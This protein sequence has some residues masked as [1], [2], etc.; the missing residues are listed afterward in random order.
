[1]IELKSIQEILGTSFLI[2][3]YQRGYRWTRRQVRDLL[4]DIDE[5][6]HKDESN[7]IYCIQPLVVH[8]HLDVTIDSIRAAQSIQEVKD[9]LQGTWDVVDGQQRLTTV[10]ILLQYLCNVLGWN[11]SLYQLQYETR[12][13]HNIDS[14]TFLNHITEEGTRKTAC[15][16]IDYY[17]FS[18]AYQEIEKWFSMSCEKKEK[19][20]RTKFLTTLLSQVKFIWYEIEEDTPEEVFT[21]LNIG[22]ISLTNSELIKALLLNRSNFSFKEID[23]VAF[24]QRRIASQWDEIEYTLQNPEFWLFLNHPNYVKATR[25][26]FIFELIESQN[27]LGPIDYALYSRLDDYNIFGYFYGYMIK[28]K[29][30]PAIAIKNIWEKVESIFQTM[31][32]WYNNTELYHYIGYLIYAGQYWGQKGYDI[33]SLMDKWHQYQ[34]KTD[35]K[36]MF[37]KSQI[38]RILDAYKCN[39][40]D[41]EKEVGKK[42][43]WAPLLLLHNIET[44]I[45]Q[46]AAIKSNSKYGTGITY[47]FPF[48]L[49]KKEDWNIEHIDS[50]TENLLTDVNSQQS[51]LLNSYI[52]LDD[53]NLKEKIEKFLKDIN[54]QSLNQDRRQESFR[55]LWTII[56]QHEEKDT[57]PRLDD[58]EKNLVWNYALL[59]A[60]TNKGYGNA[61]F[62]AKRRILIGKDRGVKIMPAKFIDGTIKSG[63]EERANSAFIPPCTKYVFLKYYSSDASSPLVWSKKDAQDYKNNIAKV[64]KEYLVNNG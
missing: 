5:F 40:L 3:K 15:L 26:D 13:K 36:K 24:E 17:H 35:F 16:N 30:N 10:N 6:M 2:P 22:K 54:S 52:G 32:E 34:S 46:N 58:N 33:C 50:S 11:L 12:R 20:Y 4:S 55:E 21:R 64:L 27:L 59:D 42:T 23:R 7:A 47:R 44:V 53:N 61:L 29:A 51:W 37:I 19:A 18:M 62:P 43:E 57:T 45:Q 38:C 56:V 25:I 9:L 31:K 39:D 1:M 14:K 60:N 8:N 48:H 63:D 28:N 49:L 41:I